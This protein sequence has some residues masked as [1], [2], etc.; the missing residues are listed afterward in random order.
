MKTTRKMSI[1][2]V[3]IVA[4]LCIAY[5]LYDVKQQQQADIDLVKKSK[6][7][8]VVTTAI[9]KYEDIKVGISYHGIFEPSS[10]VT[11]VSESQ[12]KIEKLAFN[13]GDFVSEGTTIAWLDN[14]LIGYQLETSEAAYL[15][16]QDDL[17][18]FE[19]LSA[20]EAI[21]AQQLEEIRLAFKN[22]KSSFL[23]IKKQYENSFIKA[24]ISGTV[25]KRYFE[26]GSFIA[27]GS[28]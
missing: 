23:T 27:P 24:P 14:D 3:M 10:E 15:K 5:K 6:S 18:R 20:G 19:N 13:E 4:V 1:S 12:G 21:S 26:K 16:A 2:I 9:A 8:I 11:V 17:K 28:Q 7:E 22:A 25:S